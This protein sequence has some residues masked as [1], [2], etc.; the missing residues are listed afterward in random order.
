MRMNNQLD[1]DQ[2]AEDIEI[3]YKGDDVMLTQNADNRWSFVISGNL[4]G[5]YVDAEAAQ[6]A[7]EDWIDDAMP[8]MT[9]TDFYYLVNN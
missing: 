2:L 1:F 9:E 6:E 5:S 8:A 4:Y 7:A 3:Q